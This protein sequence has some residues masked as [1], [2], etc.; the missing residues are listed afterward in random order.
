[1]ADSAGNDCELLDAV[2]RGFG[3][4]SDAAV[5]GLLGMSRAAIHSVRHGKRRLGFAQR[6]KILDKIGFLKLQNLLE[7]ISSEILAEK[8]RNASGRHAGARGISK[9]SRIEGLSEDAILL[10]T[11]KYCLDFQTD[12]ELAELLG[13]GRNVISMVRSGRTSIGPKPRLRLLQ[14]VESIDVDK[15][16]EVL[17]STDMMIGELEKWAE[18]RGQ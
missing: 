18:S 5:A 1:M 4:K 12:D 7:S 17:A 8:I 3:L 6:L 15:I 9:L 11:A 2:K 16:E 10:E 14:A 13:V